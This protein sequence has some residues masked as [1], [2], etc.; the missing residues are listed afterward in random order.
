MQTLTDA[1]IKTRPAHVMVLDDEPECFTTTN[2]S[3]NS[4]A[5]LDRR[6]IRLEE[7]PP[8]PVSIFSLTGQQISTSGNLTNVAAQAKGGKSAVIGALLGS[9]LA[10]DNENDEADCF[11]F[12]AA[13]TNGKAVILFDT[14]QSRFD[15]W[16]LVNRAATRAGVDKLPPNFRIYGL[17]DVPTYDRRR[18]LAAELERASGDCNGIHSALVDGVADLCKD[19]NDTLEAFGLV[20]QLVKLAVLHDAPIVTVLHENPSGGETGKTRGHLGSQLERKAESNLRVAKDPKGVSTIFS[21]RCRRASIPKDAGP[22]FAFCNE[23]GMHVTVTTEAKADK[24]DEKRKTEQPAVDAVFNGTVGNLTW[25]D[26]KKRM[27]DIGK[28]TPRTAERRI[29]EWMELG[30]ITSLVKGEYCRK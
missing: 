10:A 21:D 14:E 19:P 25:S 27:I 11:G 23:A 28:M 4:L 15:A 22:R 16:Q 5:E 20:E 2:A 9:I 8:L 17:L 18:Y 29:T 26:L 30:L 12:V 24:A 7:Q 1:I 3:A 6:R 13:P